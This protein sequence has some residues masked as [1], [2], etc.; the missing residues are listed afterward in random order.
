[1]TTEFVFVCGLRYVAIELRFLHCP[2]RG[3]ITRIRLQLKRESKRVFL[4]FGTVQWNSSISETVRNGTHVHIRSRLLTFLRGT[5]CIYIQPTRQAHDVPK[6]TFSRSFLKACKSVKMSGTNYFYHHIL[7]PMYYIYEKGGNRDVLEL[8]RLCSPAST[9][10]SSQ[11][12][13]MFCA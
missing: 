5:L 1:M 12:V 11:F 3:Y 10:I 9:T 6:I 8:S 7:S 13:I 4:Y 2:Y